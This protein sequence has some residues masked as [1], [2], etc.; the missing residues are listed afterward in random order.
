M[1][2]RFCFSFLF[3]GIVGGTLFSSCS[4][5][6]YSDINGLSD[7]DKSSLNIVVLDP[8]EEQSTRTTYAGLT[9]TFEN[10]DAIGI[11]AV[12]ANGNIQASNVK[13]TK[14][15]S[16]WN[17][18]ADIS[19]NPNWRYYA[20]YPYVAS[21][22]TPDFSLSGLDNQFS[23]FITDASDKFHH[24]D[25]STKA[26]FSSA[27]LMI[28]QGSMSSALT[29]TFSMNH[30]KGLVILTDADSHDV[31]P[32]IPYPLNGKH[33]I[34]VKPSVY[35]TIG[36]ETLAVSGG[37]YLSYVLYTKVPKECYLS[38]TA[39]ENGSFSFSGEGLSYSIDGGETWMALAA[40]TSTPAVEK[41]SVILWKNNTSLTPESGTGIGKFSATGT[42][43]AKG[44]VMSLFYGDDFLG[45]TSLSGKNYAFVGLFSNNARLRNANGL[46]LPATTLSSYCYRQMFRGCTGLKTAPA[47]PAKTLATYCYTGMF[48]G[49][50]SL[51]TA[52]EL[53][54]TTL[55]NNCYTQMFTGCSNLSYIK[56]AF[57]TKPTTS[58]TSQWVKN[59]KSSGTFVKN[60]K[61][62]WSVTG[63]D[64]IP[65]GWTVTT[66]KP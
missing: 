29:V 12:D 43:D 44:N 62:T 20:Y 37:H 48:Q 13:Y 32:Y 65:S 21:P 26:N 7:A 2:N 19:F 64:G 27:D 42:F 51:A 31:S 49:C 56:A 24:F 9:T 15:G 4:N 59:V 22:Y 54:A 6:E 39:V 40:N 55:K 1:D 5:D 52:P 25:Q 60:S 3:A 57:T 11:Y 34:F 17:A 47:L 36:P 18:A 28:A 30:K 38:F 63:V 61:A 41:G 50:T 58:Y 35:V 14:N 45:K 33:F 16:E 46:I 66:Y 10:G 53:P 23:A 8:Q